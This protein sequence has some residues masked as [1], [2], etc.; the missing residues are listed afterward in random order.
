MSYLIAGLGNPG[1][2]YQYT[3]HNLGFLI[4]EKM[5]EEFQIVLQKKPLGR[6]GSGLMEGKKIYLLMPSTYMNLSGTAVRFY[7]DYYKIPYANIIVAVDDVEIPFGSMRLRLK[8]GSGG[9]NGLKSIKQ[10]LG[11]E[12]YPRLRIGIRTKDIKEADLANFVLENFTDPERQKLPKII[13]EAVSIIK[14]FICE[15]R[16]KAIER[17]SLFQLA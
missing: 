12:E 1:K 6:I 11:T 9:H 14:T 7:S 3:R 2:K 5:A 8:G 16:D 4:L 10:H 17:A 15:S 13:D